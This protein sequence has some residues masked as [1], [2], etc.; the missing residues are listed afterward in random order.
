MFG[1]VR[2]VA[3]LIIVLVVVGSLWY[4]TSMREQLA[5]SKQSN[6]KLNQAVMVQQDLIKQV[7]KDVGLIQNANKALS[8]TIQAQNKDLNSLQ[9]RLNTNADGS[10]RDLGQLAITNTKSIERA[11]NRGSQNAVRCLEIASGAPLTVEERSA[12]TAS[13]INRECPS[14]ANPNY[15]PS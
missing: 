2:I 14:I 6:E 7:K 3:I 9:S 10:S 11:V 13:E 5:I 4:V 12:K 8:N 15:K 1:T